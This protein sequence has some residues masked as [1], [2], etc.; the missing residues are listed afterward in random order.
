M[1]AVERIRQIEK[2]VKHDGSA[3][4]AEL[5]RLFNVTEET[6][7]R[8]LEK[9]E[10]EHK[11]V[12]SHGGADSVGDGTGEIPYF[13]REVRQ[14]HEK[15]AIARAAVE[16]VKEG[17]TIFIDA[18]STAL[19]MAR[20]LPDLKFTVLT[21]AVKVMIELAQRPRIR[22][23][24]TG[25]TLASESLSFYGPSSEKF[26]EGFHVDKIF[27]SCKGLDLQRGASESS[28]LLAAFKRR[29]V[30]VADW[31]CLLADHT[32]LGTNALAVFASLSDFEEIITDKKADA[33]DVKN[34]RRAVK[35]VVLA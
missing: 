6:I 3:R 28:E 23:I 25:G 27:L 10:R 21:N 11:I 26:L 32:K 2:R 30:S 8:D 24:A 1:L 4:V 7:R 22:V 16:R 20:L 31:R 35:S 9:L 29:A 14:V 15:T 13:E 33:E 34:L 19:Q 17:D 5:A 18:S 12:R